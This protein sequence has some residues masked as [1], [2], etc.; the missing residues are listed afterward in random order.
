MVQAPA[1]SQTPEE[2][3]QSQTQAPADNT[4]SNAADGAADEASPRQP[5][6][7]SISPPRVTRLGEWPAIKIIYCLLSIHHNYFLF[8]KFD[9]VIN[10][11]FIVIP[12]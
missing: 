3:S 9:S 8:N 10:V 2:P 6:S 4:S 1:D 11:V 7:P 12:D 5:R